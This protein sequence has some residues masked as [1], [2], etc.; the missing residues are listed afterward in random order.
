MADKEI[1]LDH[2]DIEN[3]QT[4]TEVQSRAFKER[5]LDLLKDDVKERIDDFS[6]GKRILKV[7]APKKYFFFHSK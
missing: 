3:P 6:T 7:K 4:I 1:V 2:K 5:G